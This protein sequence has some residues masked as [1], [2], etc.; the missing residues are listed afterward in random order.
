M[1]EEL[2]KK[3]RTLSELIDEILDW[4]ALKLTA[5]QLDNFNL[6]SDPFLVRLSDAEQEIDNWIDAYNKLNDSYQK[7]IKQVEAKLAKAILRYQDYDHERLELKQKLQFLW[8]TIPLDFNLD[9]GE[10][11]LV[12]TKKQWRDWLKKFEELLKEDEAK[13]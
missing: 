6:K 1:N 5:V 13:P 11:S 9:T 8:N 3:A 4:D 12:G 7:E 2:K 10:V